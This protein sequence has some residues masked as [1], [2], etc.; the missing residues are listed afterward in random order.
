LIDY[1]LLIDDF[2]F[3]VLIDSLAHDLHLNKAIMLR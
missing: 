2:G 3:L 1:W